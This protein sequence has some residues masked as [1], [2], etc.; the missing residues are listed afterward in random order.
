LDIIRAFSIFA[1]KIILIQ[2]INRLTPHLVLRMKLIKIALLVF[3][4]VLSYTNSAQSQ[5]YY[6]G[7]FE[8]IKGE[9]HLKGRPFVMAFG[10][11]WCEPCKRMEYE[12][13]ESPTIQSMLDKYFLYYKV[14]A[15]AEFNLTAVMNEVKVYP[16]LI[17]FDAEGKE[18]S[19]LT[20][21]S[22][23]NVVLRE[24]LKHKPKV[25]NSTFTQFR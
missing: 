20:G 23:V 10:A 3:F 18:K 2:K 16:T 13:F 15:E 6:Q 4:T 22:D 1:L 25:P 7:S 9:A 24:L 12:V 17:F 8:E 21:Y 11:P 14:N 19:R 5:T